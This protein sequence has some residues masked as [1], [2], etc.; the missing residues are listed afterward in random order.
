LKK[1]SRTRFYPLYEEWA[2]DLRPKLVNEVR[3]LAT[4]VMDGQDIIPE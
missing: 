4:R 2:K 3:T 1:E